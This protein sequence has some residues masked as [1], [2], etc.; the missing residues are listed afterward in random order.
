MCFFPFQNTRIDSEAYKRGITEFKCGQCPECLSDKA[1]YWSLRCSAEAQTNVGMMITL[2]YDDYKRDKYG[3]KTSEELPPN[4]DLKVDKRDCQLFIKRLRKYFDG[5][6]LSY[7][8][9]A[10]YGA[11]THRAHYHA[12]IFGVEFDDLVKYKRSKRGNWIYKSP[13]LEKIWGMGICTVDA[14]RVNAQV[15]RYCTKYCA[16]DSRCDDTFML[17]SHGIGQQWLLDNF[18]GKSY[19][20][21]GREYPIPRDIWQKK[22][23]LHIN[24]V[25]VDDPFIHYNHYSNNEQFIEFGSYFFDKYEQEGLKFDNIFPVSATVMETSYLLENRYPD[26]KYRSLSFYVRKFGDILHATIMAGV[27]ILKRK[28]FR[29][30][31][32]DWSV[33]QEYIQYW[34][35]KAETLALTRKDIEKRINDLPNE[36]YF[37]YKQRALACLA[38]RKQ[39]RYAHPNFDYDDVQDLEL[40]PRLEKSNRPEKARERCFVR[41]FGHLPYA[42]CHITANDTKNDKSVQIGRYKFEVLPDFIPSPF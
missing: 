15:S 20:I 3:R 27:N 34:Q 30:Y 35:K 6:K 38:K 8:L 4:R 17:F 24:E 31:R 42:P 28:L 41:L 23:M 9:T 13:T 18:N 26:Y 5:E 21:D 12:L 10:E 37:I 29:K 22:T 11:R 19:I 2:T 32:D 40:P 7:L 25:Y 14:V 16:K 33:Y 36:K 1:R 39:L